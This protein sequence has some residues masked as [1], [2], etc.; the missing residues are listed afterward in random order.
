MGTTRIDRTGGTLVTQTRPRDSKHRAILPSLAPRALIERGLLP[1][2]P[3]AALAEVGRIQAPAAMNGE[4]DDK[5]YRVRDLAL[6]HH[7]V[8]LP[9]VHRN[10]AP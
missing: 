3:A 10:H 9:L 2:F 8:Y 4:P 6:P 7:W 1:D 5:E